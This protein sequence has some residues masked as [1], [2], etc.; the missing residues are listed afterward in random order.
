MKLI[1]LALWRE[2]NNQL[3]L[4]KTLEAKAIEHLNI[5]LN[6]SVESARKVSYQGSVT[7][8]PYGS[9]G[10]TR[11][12]LALDL[13]DG[14]HLDSGELNDLINKAMDLLV[15]QYNFLIRNGRYGVKENLSPKTHNFSN[16]DEQ[17]LAIEDYSAIKLAVLSVQALNA[18][19]IE[20]S[21]AYLSEATAELQQK[22]M[23][24]IEQDRHATYQNA[25]DTSVINTLGY[26]KAK[27]A[28]ELDNG[29]QFSDKE[30]TEMVNRAQEKLIKAYNNLLRLERLGVRDSL[31]NLVY[32]KQT[33]NNSVPPITD[34]DA[35]VYQILANM[36]LN[37]KDADSIEKE[38]ALSS[39][40]RDKVKENLMRELEEKRHGS[41]KTALNNATPNSY[42][43][44]KSRL[45]LELP[46]GLKISEFEIEQGIRKALEKLA[47]RYNT[48]I[49]TGRF[50]IK[51]NI[52]PI[53]SIPDMYDSSMPPEPLRNF[54][55]IKLAF[56]SVGALNSGAADS[57]K[58]LEDQAFAK[59]EE[60]IT[61]TLETKRHAEYQTLLD[62]ST[63]GTYGWVKAR[64]ALELPNG[65]KLSD[66]EL[67]EA[68]LKGQE[69]LVSHYN[70][71]IKSG[72]LGVKKPIDPI[73]IT[74]TP[75]N[76]SALHIPDF[77]ATKAAVLAVSSLS[78]GQAELALG[79]EKEA[80]NYLERNLITALETDRH[81]LYTNTLNSA[82]PDSF[83]FFKARLALDLPDGLRLSDAEV[84]RLVNRAEETMIL[85][86]KWPGTVEEMKLTMPEDG[87][88][89]LPYNI[90]TVLSA[91]L[92][93]G[94]P[95]PIYGRS[96]DYHENGP[97]YS[98]AD[99]NNQDP[100]LIDR[101][102]IV[103]EGRRSKVYFVRGNLGEEKCIRILYK[104]KA[105]PH[106]SDSEKMY[107]L[108]YPAIFEMVPGFQAQALSP[109]KAKYHEE[110]ALRL[111]R[112]ELE[113]NK[114]PNR[115]NIK[116]QANAFS[117]SEV[118]NLV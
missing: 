8:F 103:A 67:T 59:L 109:E 53:T 11:A 83:G 108:N 54:E 26:F 30:L 50:G 5:K 113:E 45:A 114:G 107:L 29:L 1:L 16:N 106:T 78:A 72:R 96:Y 99:S 116:V 7:N 76:S 98:T 85:R 66:K 56:L 33:N 65:L 41:Y 118:Q 70:F 4:A 2:E 74:S 97:G 89:Y 105:I 82:S 90:E 47:T 3:D 91:A 31:P 71:L 104:R 32:T 15:D 68:V 112:A 40:A 14:L 46:D 80:Q 101:G 88:V 23:T 61:L 110:N 20:A 18:N 73:N 87:N 35:I 79:M 117:L 52:P 63:R 48:F 95:I 92:P 25:L 34:Y 111:L 22:L 51:S 43:Q 81:T 93:S 77:E 9:M 84:G 17:L 37:S 57:A 36:A 38:T 12:K 69:K 10:F 28:L 39:L 60:L 94:K 19:Q 21:K 58:N 100:A 115:Y 102:E 75:S 55:M 27:L 24:K 6:S 49:T 64:L 13:K 62:N 44:I 86:G 42:L